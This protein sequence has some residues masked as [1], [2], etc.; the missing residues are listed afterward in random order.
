[1]SLDEALANEL[2]RGLTSL[3]AGAVEG[4]QRFAERGR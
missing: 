3:E 4:A 2:R 1:M